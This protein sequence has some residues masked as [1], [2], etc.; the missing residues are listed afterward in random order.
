MEKYIDKDLEN[1]LK[2]IRRKIHSKAEVGF[3]LKNTRRIV[4]EELESLGCTVKS[5]GDGCIYTVIEGEKAGKCLLM[6]ADMDAL[7]IREQTVREGSIKHLLQEDR[8]SLTK[9]K[10][11][12]YFFYTCVYRHQLLIL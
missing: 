2:R 4:T 8:K 1:E 6:R 5:V 9:C 7:P 11:G 3:E 12:T 10:R